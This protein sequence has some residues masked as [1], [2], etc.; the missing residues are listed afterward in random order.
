MNEWKHNDDGDDDDS[1]GKVKDS[2][3]TIEEKSFGK[4]AIFALHTCQ[5]AMHTAH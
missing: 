1:N 3:M 5:L 4:Y 2:D